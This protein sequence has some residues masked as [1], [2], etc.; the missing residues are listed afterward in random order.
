MTAEEWLEGKDSVAREWFE[1]LPPES[2]A[3]V[4]KYPPELCYRYEERGHYRVVSYGTPINGAPEGT[5]PVALRMVHGTDSFMP[6]L[7]V[8]GCDPAKLTPCGCGHWA[9][10]TPEQIEVLRRHIAAIEADQEMLH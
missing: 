2:Q 1:K 6:G 10:A 7:G 5:L 9:P 4:L 3:C 8:F